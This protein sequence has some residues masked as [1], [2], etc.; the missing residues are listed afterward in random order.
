MCNE[1]RWK[2]LWVDR[3]LD[4]SWLE[5]MNNIRSVKIESSCAGHRNRLPY[6]TYR[7]PGNANDVAL[8]LA[9]LGNYARVVPLGDRRGTFVQLVKPPAGGGFSWTT[10]RQWWGKVL[11]WLEEWYGKARTNHG[12]VR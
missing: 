1:R 7:G 12:K 2:G 8:A 3:G 11:K 5:R 4:D 9:H 6:I 10:K